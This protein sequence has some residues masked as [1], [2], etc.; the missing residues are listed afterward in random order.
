MR[1]GILGAL[2]I[3]RE[4]EPVD[5]A[6]GRLR[7]LLARLALAAGRPVSVDALVEAV[8]DG[9]PPGD[10]QHALQSLV[11]RLRRSLGDGEVIA[12]AP[13]GYR[14]ALAPEAI[15]AHRF[16]T[17]A[18]AGAAA[19]RGGDPERASATLEQAL[20]LWR[21]PALPDLPALAGALE[22]LRLA[23]LADRAEAEHALGRGG[24]MV[25]ELEA[26]MGEHP[27]NERL[28]ARHIQALFAAGRQADALSAYE[29]MRARLAD[30][31]GAAPSP[32][33]Q[34][35]HLAV[36]RGDTPAPARRASNLRAPVTSF[37]GRE[38]EI[39]RIGALLAQSRLVTLVGPG[40]A[41]KTRLAGEAL[42][43][44]VDRV[45]GGVWMVE[46]APVTAAVEVVPAVHSALGLRDGAVLE[47]SGQPPLDALERLIDVLA[48]RETILILD[49][50]EHLIATVAEVADELLAGCPDL[51]IVATSR[52][53]LAIA[54][55][56]LAPVAP[57]PDDPAVQL[58]ADRAAAARPGFVV[59]EHA[60]EICR[61]LDGLPLAIELAAARLRSMPVDQL[62]ARLDDRFRL[63]TG[64]SRT[65][66][67]RHRTLRAVVDWSWGL[68]DEPERRLARRLAVFSA[69]ATEES[70]AAV[71]GEADVLDGLA[72][73]VDRSLVVSEAPRYRMLE[74]IREYALE[75]LDEAG[76]LEATRGAHARW[77]AELAARADP[78]L[79]GPRQREWLA[80]LRADRDDVFA[81]LRWLG[82]TGDA[83]GALRLTVDLLWFWML[84]GAPDE[85]QAWVEFAAALPGEADPVDR[86]IADGI[87]TLR[88]AGETGE[89]APV[90]ALVERLEREGDGRALLALARPILPLFAGDDEI[91]HRRLAEALEH[92]D[93]WVRAA[94]LL[95]RGHLAENLGDQAHMRA[96]LERAAEGFSAVGDSWG[97]AMTLSSVASTLMLAGDLD[98]AETALD[99]AM[100]RLETLDGSSAGGLLWLRLADLRLRRGDLDEARVL[101][102]RA[103]EQADLRSDENLF[104][105][106]TMARIAWLVGDADALR[107]EVAEAAVRMERIGRRRPEQDHARV[108]VD[109]LLVAVAL[110][111]GDLERAEAAA[112]TAV[113]RAI[114]TNDMPIVASAGVM[115][116]AVAAA[117]GRPLEAAERLGATT[118]LRGAEDLSNPELARLAAALREALGDAAFAAAY[119]RGRALDREAAL[120][121]MP[122]VSA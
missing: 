13:G 69:G 116:A 63:L 70:A 55:E 95:I 86:L 36:L 81:A 118:V 4:G 50:C 56:S 21:G 87:L 22:D 14:L 25:A 8:W 6:G 10:R 53:P 11:S 91:A 80:R 107:R 12:P 108:I 68:L 71:C 122:P 92:P 31:L 41:G 90:R 35:A 115:S 52:E 1:V 39:E 54:G 121:C 93:P 19:L 100:E 65:A 105:R 64:G 111:D 106:A 18:A 62:A 66:L 28:A 89:L 60:L 97:L 103:V 17:L 85:A 73:L 104:A 84:T 82:D 43:G 57:L 76:E 37:V 20:A 94:A 26:A 109:V 24:A 59:D 40:G 61:R 120:S 113:A 78:E 119:E 5:V 88:H 44:W 46:L 58:F 79:R 32:E 102:Q 112:A 42:A 29:R 96:D 7:A 47:R 75:K 2:Q 101:V 67:P 15:D 9:D 99:E 16:E 51:R 45:P 33:L 34:A 83:R 117:A 74:T 114:G 98:G 3:E 27:L 30:E 23:A 48:E 49:N 38:P 77:F 110:E 72:A